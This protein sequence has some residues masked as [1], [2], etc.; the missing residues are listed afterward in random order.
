MANLPSPSPV[1]SVEVTTPSLSA[2][3]AAASTQATPLISVVATVPPTQQGGANITPQDGTEFHA[4]DERDFEEIE[5]GT[6]FNGAVKEIKLNHTTKTVSLDKYL[7]ALEKK[8]QKR[9][10]ELVKNEG[11]K[12]WVMVDT[13]YAKVQDKDKKITGHLWSRPFILFNEFEVEQTVHRIIEEIEARNANFMRERSGLAIDEILGAVIHISLHRPLAGS[14]FQPLP[15]FLKKKEAIINV[16]NTDNRCFGYAVLSALH[17]ALRD[18]SNRP[19]HYN[20]YF[21][22]HQL[23]DIIY[24][25]ELNQIPKLENRIG[26]NLNIF[27]FSNGGVRRFPIYI[28]EKQY[29]KTVNLL[30]WDGHY[31]WIKN[32]DRL[33]FDLTKH[34]EP[35]HICMC[36]LS[37]F[38]TQD[39]LDQH[40]ANCQNRGF[41][42]TVYSMPFPGTKLKFEHIRNQLPVPF[43]IVA[44][45]EALVI[46]P[47]PNEDP[48]DPT[49]YQNHTPCAAGLKLI[50]SVPEV[51][52]AYWQFRGENCIVQFLEKLI[53]IEQTCLAYLFNPQRMI[54]N[55]EDVEA[56]NGAAECY[57]CKGKF[58][59]TNSK[60]RDHDHMSGKY[61]GAAHNSCNMQLRRQYKIPVFF[62]NWR[63]YDSHFIVQ[64]LPK[65]AKRKVSII[66][67]SLE[68]Y[69]VLSWA[70]HIVFK[71]SLQFMSYSLDKLATFLLKAGRDNFKLLIAEFPNQ[72]VDLLL[73]K[74]F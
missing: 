11:I 70:E 18:H 22:Q 43:K 51:K 40:S 68:K 6:A 19:S 15:P 57:I 2:A 17:P 38:T 24:P 42:G 28:S 32:F 69:L 1:P 41:S 46:K 53:E 10:A 39:V 20:R 36:C 47:D 48:E 3:T 13:K 74:G 44:D 9:L 7:H 59:Q 23:N 5:A 56:F 21:Q 30:Y 14:S 62:H 58:S 64:E 60:V 55:D 16:K 65:F 29:P 61:R 34:K 33:M 73:R 37:H 49:F 25:V 27:G 8:L 54:M 52:E 26:I 67:Q 31:A 50:S 4:M 45:T 63:G 72:P 66:G 12:A 71:D 35:K